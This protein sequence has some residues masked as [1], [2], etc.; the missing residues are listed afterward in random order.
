M[1]N[2]K[3]KRARLRRMKRRRAKQRAA[4]PQP[5]PSAILVAK[6]ILAEVID[7]LPKRALLDAIREA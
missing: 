3:N 1:R 7:P 5:K 6:G 2:P 4:K